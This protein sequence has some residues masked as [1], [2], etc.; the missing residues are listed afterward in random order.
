MTALAALAR[1][2][3]T[4]GRTSSAC[5][6]R[7]DWI[8]VGVGVCV[9]SVG[10]GSV[11]VVGGGGDGG[12]VEVAGACHNGSAALVVRHH[13]VHNSCRWQGIRA[14]APRL[15]ATTPSR[16]LSVASPPSG[17]S[18]QGL[19]TRISQLTRAEG[20]QLACRPSVQRSIGNS[21]RTCE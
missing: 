12:A 8:C 20:A 7:P 9:G 21:V 6:A 2:Q 14:S 11:G 5:D 17:A 13:R 18:I 3:S 10:V 16:K 19:S 1:F 4:S 15:A